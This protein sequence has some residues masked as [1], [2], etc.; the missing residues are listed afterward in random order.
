MQKNNEVNNG[1]NIKTN[2]QLHAN[3]AART[4]HTHTRTHTHTHLCCKSRR[5]K[6]GT[7][8]RPRVANRR[9][10]RT[11]CWL[12]GHTRRQRQFKHRMAMANKTSAIIVLSPIW[13]SIPHYI[14][15]QLQQP[16]RHA[17]ADGHI[18]HDMLASTI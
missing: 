11:T 9:Q 5:A 8:Y 12:R 2:R 4:P 14:A 1:K 16:I 17:Q 18:C 15:E 6:A 3:V 7:R 13:A 10:Q